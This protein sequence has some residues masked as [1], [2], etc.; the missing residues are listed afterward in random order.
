MQSDLLQV[1]QPFGVVAK[2]IVLRAK[3][4]EPYLF[5]AFAQVPVV[6]W[7]CVCGFCDCNVGFV[8]LL[9]HAL[10]QMDDLATSLCVIQYYTTIQHSVR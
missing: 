6:W 1:V 5:H 4:Q 8:L 10:V 3:N 2:F 7:M 9:L